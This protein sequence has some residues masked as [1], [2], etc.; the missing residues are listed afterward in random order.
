MSSMMAT[1]EGG[2][3]RLNM[4]RAGLWLFF[5]SEGFM[6]AGLLATRFALLPGTRPDLDQTVG[7]I[8]TSILL[9]SSFFMY[10]AETA[11]AHGYQDGGIGQRELGG[12][13]E[14]DLGTQAA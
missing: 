11:I 7:L 2:F 10:R 9:L 3:S 12:D 1:H 6:F 4:N 8:V 13:P 14:G 5:V